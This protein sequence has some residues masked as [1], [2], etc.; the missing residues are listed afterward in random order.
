ME[1]IDTKDFKL[2]IAGGRKFNDFKTLCKV[3]DNLLAEKIKQGYT[4]I[5]VSGGAKGAD[6]LGGKYA[7]LRGFQLEVMNADWKDITTPPVSI[8]ENSYG[9]YNRL[10]GMVRNHAM[11]DYADALVVFWDGLSTG[12]ADMQ[13]YMKKIGKP[14]RIWYY[15]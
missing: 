15:H 14:V 4:I 6:N 8:A 13:G 5:I 7:S 2:I 9:K 11:G 12:T 3:V 10:A 1:H